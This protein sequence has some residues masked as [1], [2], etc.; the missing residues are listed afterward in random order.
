MDNNSIL[1][2]GKQIRGSITEGVGKLINSEKLKS[3]GRADQLVG[4]AQEAAG[5]LKDAILDAKTM[6]AAEATSLAEHAKAS[7]KQAQGLMHTTAGKA[8]HD[9]GLEIKGNIEQIEGSL[10]QG[11]ADIKT[12]K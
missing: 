2:K 1:G 7:A 12:P 10:R 11:I 9:L 5:H 6:A 4:H 8:N 3:D